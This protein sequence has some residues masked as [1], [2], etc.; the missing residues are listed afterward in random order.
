MIYHTLADD[1]SA[2]SRSFFARLGDEAPVR[3]FERAFAAGLGVRH[4]VAFAFARSGLYYALKAKDFPPGSEIIMSPLS[5]KEFLDAVVMLGLKPVF[6]DI[7]PGTLCADPAAVERLLTPNTKAILLT[8]LYGF[9]P[10]AEKL[11]APLRKKGLF[12]IEDISHNLNAAW[13]G[14]KLGSFGDVSLYS[15]SST[16]T[17]DAY[18]GGLACTDDDAL[19][20]KLRAFQSGLL[21]TPRRVLRAKILTDLARNFFSGGPAFAL[22]VFPLVRLIE[23]LRPGLFIRLLGA[24]PEYTRVAEMP[25]EWRQAFTS[26]QAAEGLKHLRRAPG[27]DSLRRRNAELLMRL[28][29]EEPVARTPRVPEGAVNVYWQFPLQVDDFMRFS[30]FFAQRGLD[31][32]TPSLD[33][34]SALKVYREFNRATPNAARL[35]KNGA[36]IPVYPKLREQDIIRIAGAIRDYFRGEAGGRARPTT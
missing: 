12:V 3:E 5:I 27:L 1:L 20:E 10:D 21:K 17:L 8:Y 13:C 35:K 22:L 30:A 29:E 32:G 26:F 23:T 6:A 31:T 24:D 11:I 9:T 18:G 15:A 33:L 14:K 16:K 4:A 7:E 2:L 36:F 28:L 34:C 25:E 19:A